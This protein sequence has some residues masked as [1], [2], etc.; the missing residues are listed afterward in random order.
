[1]AWL[2]FGTGYTFTEKELLVKSEPFRLRIPLAKITKACRT[3]SLLSAP[4]LSLDRLEILYSNNQV[5]LVSPAD[6][7]A[8]TGELKSR[9]P[10]A[11]IQQ[12]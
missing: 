3:R 8:F 6:R 10:G 11:D 5:V 4:A 9:C 1:M 7:Q 12:T 2:W